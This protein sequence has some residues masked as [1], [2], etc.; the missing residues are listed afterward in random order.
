LPFSSI[1]HDGN[2]SELPLYLKEE[3]MT[4]RFAL[5][6]GVMVGALMTGNLA[7]QATPATKPAPGSSMQHAQPVTPAKPMNSDSTKVSATTQRTGH[8]QAWT[9]DQIKQAQAGLAKAGY[10]KGEPTGVLGKRTR[11]AIREYQK[12]NKLPVTGR[13]S[14][15]LLTKLESA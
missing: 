8:H 4:R 9:K 12:A 14:D 7:A 3:G 10:F 2:R 15:D 11:K 1:S 6:T 13:L 5:V